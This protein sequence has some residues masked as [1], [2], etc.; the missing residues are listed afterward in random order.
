MGNLLRSGTA[1]GDAGPGTL[2]AVPAYVALLRGI[3]VGGKR[4]LKM[5]LLREVL[6]AAGCKDVATYIQSGN[7]VFGHASRTEARLRQ[8][9]E[10]RIAKAATFEVPLV[11]RTGPEMLGVIEDNPFP[12]AGDA[13]LHVLFCAERPAAAAFAKLEAARFAPEA[14]ALA[15]REVYLRLPNGIGN[16]KL[17]AAITRLSPAKEATARNWRTIQT[18]VAMARERA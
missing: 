6:E 3:N 13:E 14:W 18:L 2:A 1:N 16:S 15:N 8:D 11:L 4:S 7:A 17:A 9:L 12:D 5:T 10:A